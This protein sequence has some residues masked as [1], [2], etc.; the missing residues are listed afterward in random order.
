M[1]KVRQVRMKK[2]QKMMMMMTKIW[3]HF[4]HSKPLRQVW[5]RLKR[6]SIRT[7]SC[8]K[9]CNTKV[10]TKV[11][12]CCLNQSTIWGSWKI[13]LWIK[14]KII[15]FH[16]TRLTT[17]VT[18]ICISGVA[19]SRLS[20]HIAKTGSSCELNTKLILITWKKS[21]DYCSRA[22]IWKM[23]TKVLSNWSSRVGIRLTKR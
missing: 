1:R 4:I 2:T 18:I 3:L 12:Q 7:N 15:I 19:N 8:K 16:L 11:T 10:K 14:S 22:V 17:A 13:K 6:S 21:L 20:W 23:Q 5:K 9:L